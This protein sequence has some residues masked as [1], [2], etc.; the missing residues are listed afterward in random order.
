MTLL[1]MSELKV[2]R[3]YQEKNMLGLFFS[4]HFMFRA[5]VNSN[6]HFWSLLISSSGSQQC[7]FTSTKSPQRLYLYLLEHSLQSGDPV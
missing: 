7:L 6:S 4:C 3:Q 5:T 2:L 1:S